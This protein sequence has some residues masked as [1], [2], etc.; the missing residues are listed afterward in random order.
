MFLPELDIFTRAFYE[1]TETEIFKAFVFHISECLF[2][3]MPTECAHTHAVREGVKAGR[4][5]DVVYISDISLIFYTVLYEK[6]CYHEM[7]TLMCRHFALWCVIR[8][9]AN[10]WIDHFLQNPAGR[11]PIRL[12]PSGR[13]NWRRVS[14]GWAALRPRPIS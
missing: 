6:I 1:A 14:I 2:N 5:Y 3:T 9:P 7:Y 13:P 11:R 10:V 12:Q 8:S 4:I